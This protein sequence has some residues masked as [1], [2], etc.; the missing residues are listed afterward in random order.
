MFQRCHRV[1]VARQ[2]Q[3]EVWHSQGHQ[4]LCRTQSGSPKL[5]V[6]DV[7]TASLSFQ[8]HI[9]LTV[10]TLHCEALCSMQVPG[11]QIH[12]RV[13][14]ICNRVDVQRN[15]GQ[16]STWTQ[17]TLVRPAPSGPPC[18]AG[19]MMRL[20]GAGMYGGLATRKVAW[21]FFAAVK[22]QEL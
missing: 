22:K 11:A 1:A 21:L 18:R 15:V 2:Q 20:S 8:P 12:I 3:H 17:H 14:N 10:R 19:I 9:G 5:H 16:L 6:R 4:I 7:A 13:V